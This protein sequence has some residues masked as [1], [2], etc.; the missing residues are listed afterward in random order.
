LNNDAGY[1]TNVGTVTSV[2]NVS[3]VNGNVTLSIPAAQVNSDWNASSGVAEILNKPTLATVATSGSYNDLSNKPTIPTVNNATLTI[4][5]NGTNVSTFTANASSNVTANITVPTDVSELTN[6]SLANN[7]L[8]NLGA[9]GESRFHALKAYADNGELL[10]DAKGLENVKNYAHSTFD[11]SKFTVVGSPVITDDGVASGFSSSNYINGISVNVTSGQEF[12]LKEKFIFKPDTVNSE[13]LFNLLDTN[14]NS[15]FYCIV[16]KANNKIAAAM[17]NLGFAQST[18]VLTEGQSY[19]IEVRTNLKDYFKIYINGI[20]EI[21][22]SVTE[23]SI[24]LGFILIGRIGSQQFYQ[25]YIDLK[26]FSITVDG[27]PVFSGNKTGVDTIKPDDYT[28]VGTP[29]ISADGIMTGTFSDSS[30]VYTNLPSPIS[31]ME[32]DFNFISSAIEGYYVG[33]KDLSSQNAVAIYSNGTYIVPIIRVVNPD[34]TTTQ[35]TADAQTNFSSSAYVEGKLTWNGTTYTYTLYQPSTNTTKTFTISSS[36]PLA[37]LQFVFA[38]GSSAGCDLNK[39]KYYV[40]GS[41]VYQPCLKIPYTESNTG[42]RIVDSVYRSRVNDMAQQFGYAN[43]YTLSDTDFTLPQ[44]E[45][46]GLIGQQTLRKS[47]VSGINRQFLYSDRTQIL[48]GSC[49]SG[50]EVTLQKPF[51]NANYALSVPYSAKTATAFTPTQTGD[52]FAI[53]EGVL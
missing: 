1:T 16:N 4:Q 45:E 13:G 34:T 22:S 17:N 52:W 31:S 51:A 27:I 5:K 23:Q 25:G 35:L 32:L 28:V 9:G 36:L 11:R 8:S 19:E 41:L 2:N 43:F 50:T 30:T 20:L 29:T 21:N 10:T 26:Q 49:T 37:P 14:Y 47:T 7:D 38:N 6:T 40:D 39:I 42:S 53:G 18:T 48:T 46:Y 3:P 44:V 33:Y 24:T 12:I 15:V